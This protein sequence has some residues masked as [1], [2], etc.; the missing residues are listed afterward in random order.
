MRSAT[1]AAIITILVSQLIVILVMADNGW[2]DSLNVFAFYTFIFGV[3]GLIPGV[4]CLLVRKRNTGFGII[5]GCG[6][7]LVVGYGACT[8]APGAFS[9]SI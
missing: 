6:I 9:N 2:E 8:M 3:I 5:I 1:K 7:M 4:T